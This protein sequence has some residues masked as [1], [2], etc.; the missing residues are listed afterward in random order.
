MGK[1]K[2][3]LNLIES[4]N[5]SITQKYKELNRGDIAF[6]LGNIECLKQ[7]LLLVNMKML[8]DER[9]QGGFE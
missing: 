3:L 7:E 6:I 2:I 4:G 1:A 9:K 8:N 5:L